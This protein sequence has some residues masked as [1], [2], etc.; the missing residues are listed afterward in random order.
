MTFICSLA[1]GVK[2]LNAVSEVRDKVYDPDPNKVFT[3]AKFAQ[4]EKSHCKVDTAQDGLP[5]FRQFAVDDSAFNKDYSALPV[6]VPTDT[7][8][9]LKECG[10]TTKK[11]LSTDA[12]VGN[13]K[14]KRFKIIAI[15]T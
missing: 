3:K 7:L 11:S 13:V 10:K 8:N 15:C 4:L 12:V 5:G 2:N 14:F 1:Y 6:F 9:H